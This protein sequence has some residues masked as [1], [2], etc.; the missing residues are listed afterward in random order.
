MGQSCISWRRQQ[1]A[2]A[3]SWSWGRQHIPLLGSALL[4]LLP[5]RR[6]WGTCRAG[7]EELLSFSSAW[8]PFLPKISVFG[9]CHT[10]ENSRLRHLPVQCQHWGH[11]KQDSS[12]LKSL[13]YKLPPSWGCFLENYFPFQVLFACECVHLSNQTGEK[14]LCFFLGKETGCSHISCS[15]YLGPAASCPQP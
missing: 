6:H 5:G 13:E 10:T 9:W 1:G 15:V 2:Q 8:A 4:L 11:I 7:P 12:R 14:S 3:G